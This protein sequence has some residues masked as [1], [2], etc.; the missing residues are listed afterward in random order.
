MIY[1]RPVKEKDGD[2]RI[3]KRFAFLPTR[4]QTHFIVFLQYYW[5]VEKLTENEIIDCSGCWDTVHYYETV[6]S[7]IT[8][9]SAAEEYLLLTGNLEG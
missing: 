4:I 2:V 8:G 7:W 1:Y 6:S 3:V 5:D 9:E